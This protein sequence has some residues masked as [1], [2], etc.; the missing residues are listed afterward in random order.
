M[1]RAE[2]IGTGYHYRSLHQTTFYRELLGVP[3][4][5][6]PNSTYVSDRIVT[7]PLHAGMTEEDAHSVVEA[8]VKV[9]A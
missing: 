7:L 8:I 2:N 1:L 3:D 4:E 9:M 5:D 6:L